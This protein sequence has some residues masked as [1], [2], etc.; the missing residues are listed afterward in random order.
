MSF[1]QVLKFNIDTRFRKK[2]FEEVLA[3]GLINELVTAHAYTEAF[4]LRE[5][6]DKNTWKDHWSERHKS[7]ESYEDKFRSY[8]YKSAKEYVH[9]DLDED[10]GDLHYEFQSW[11]RAIITPEAQEDYDQTISQHDGEIEAGTKIIADLDIITPV[12]ASQAGAPLDNFLSLFK[13][14]DVEYLLGI[15]NFI[16]FD[17]IAEH[18]YFGNPWVKEQA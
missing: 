2:R 10:T 9:R 18:H 6:E 11:M 5:E 13:K 15:D 1:R 4:L 12:I 16:R 7:I 14:H 3:A 17:R 8:G